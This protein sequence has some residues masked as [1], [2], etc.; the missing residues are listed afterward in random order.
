MTSATRTQLRDTQIFQQIF[1][2]KFVQE[3]NNFPIFCSQEWELLQVQHSAVK[4]NLLQVR[5]KPV[6][7]QNLLR[8]VA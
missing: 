2:V 3:Q 4:N 1:S 8:L 7:I 6:S 5:T